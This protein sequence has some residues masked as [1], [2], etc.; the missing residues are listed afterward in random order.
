MSK[1]IDHGIET[2]TREFIHI[3]SQ[4]LFLS[5]SLDNDAMAT[6]RCVKNFFRLFLFLSIFRLVVYWFDRLID[7]KRFPCLHSLI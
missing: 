6:L 7:R 3:L 1:T 4:F 5:L 2:L